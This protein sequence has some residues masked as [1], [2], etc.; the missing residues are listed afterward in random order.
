MFRHKSDAGRQ[1]EAHNVSEIQGRRSKREKSVRGTSGAATTWFEQILIEP[2][3]CRFPKQRMELL[4]TVGPDVTLA[5]V[6][7]GHALRLKGLRRGVGRAVLYSMF[8]AEGFKT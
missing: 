3:R 1:R 8:E 6:A 2:D 7:A 5:N 4:R